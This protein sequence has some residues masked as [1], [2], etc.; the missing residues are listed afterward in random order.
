MLD[1]TQ[2]KPDI[3]KVSQFPL[4]VLETDFLREP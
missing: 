3:F 2:N 1:S 4:A